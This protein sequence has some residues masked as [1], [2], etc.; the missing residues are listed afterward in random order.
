MAL[1]TMAGTNFDIWTTKERR[2]NWGRE[3]LLDV[4]LTAFL[5]TAVVVLSVLVY[6]ALREQP[7]LP[8][9]VI[10]DEPPH[11]R[12]IPIG[13]Y[14]CL[15]GNTTDELSRKNVARY[16]E[17]D[18][19]VVYSGNM[20]QVFAFEAQLDDHKARIKAATTHIVR[21]AAPHGLADPELEWVTQRIHQTLQ[22]VAGDAVRETL[23]TS[24]RSFDVPLLS[25]D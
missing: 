13:H 25:R 20:E 5:P 12:E 22:S 8:K 23:I 14:K 7:P 11:E 4:G 1:L 21:R 19:S 24:W 15:L 18:L 6:L 17:F 3:I 10:P 2:R 16:V 9:A